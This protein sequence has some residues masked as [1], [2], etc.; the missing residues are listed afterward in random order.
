M[1]IMFL[2]ITALL[3]FI[4]ANAQSCPIP[5]LTPTG[6]LNASSGENTNFHCQVTPVPSRGY[7]WQINGVTNAQS[8][9][10]WLILPMNVQGGV[11]RCGYNCAN[12]SNI[13]SNSVTVLRSP[14]VSISI[15]NNGVFEE[16]SD[17]TLTCSSSY[18]SYPAPSFTVS[19]VY[20][21][22]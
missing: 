12:G 18:E 2:L 19:F 4:P 9:P 10:T 3:N 11:Y 5:N 6:P 13:W 21:A 15:A 22:S 1:E 20:D 17:V 7:L 16:D 14:Q 8:D